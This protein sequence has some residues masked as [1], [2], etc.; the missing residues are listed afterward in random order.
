VCHDAWNV[1]GIARDQALDLA[2][3]VLERKPTAIT[4]WQLLEIGLDLGLECQDAVNQVG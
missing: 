2:Q 4:G 1:L 3:R